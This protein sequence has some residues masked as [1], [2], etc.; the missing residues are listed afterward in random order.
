MAFITTRSR[1]VYLKE[2]TEQGVAVEPSA[3][4]EAIAIL[5]DGFELNGEKELVERN[6]L[7][8]SIAQQIPRTGI[9]T[10][11]G[12]IGVEWKASGTTQNEPE[13]NLLYKSLLG[14]HK[15]VT[16]ITTKTSN[17]AN[18]LNLEDVDVAKLAVGDVVLV[19]E[20]GEFLVSPIKEV[21]TTTGDANITLLLSKKTAGSFSDN[22]VISKVQVYRGENAGQK[23]LTISSW[24]DTQF[25]QQA[26]GCLVSSLS[27]DNFSVG[28]IPTLNFGIEGINYIDSID[29]TSGSSIS[30]ATASTDISS[31]ANSDFDVAL[32]GQDAVTVSLTVATLDTAELIAAAL[33]SGINAAVVAG[34]VS[35][36]YNTATSKYEIVS[37]KKG[38]ASSVVITDASE[39][40]IATEL[41]LGTLNGGTETSGTAGNGLTSSFDVA[42]PP[43]ALS[44]CIYLDDEEI[45]CTDVALSVESTLGRITSTCSPNGIIST[46]STQRAVSGSFT[47]YGETDSVDLY[48][49]F[50]ENTEFSLFAFAGIPT[51]VSGEIQDVVAFYVPR[52]II[53]AKPMADADGIGTYSVDFQAGF[54]E[55]ANTDVVLVSI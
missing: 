47:T 18:V 9:K 52:A 13:Y 27:V 19:K 14:G 43:I 24:L 6:I 28:Q 29:N 22:V 40:D 44:A 37:N 51:G 53:T 31:S 39:D 54:S 49:K 10:A 2:E 15:E 50:N 45:P 41:E 48:N 5:A 20:A 1:E 33:E 26:S 16:E 55:D 25:K 34:S 3:G 12:S 30:G 8:R 38:A 35:V 36:T 23:Y 17:T 11:T 42:N 46:R 21:D 4:S 7:T 32:D